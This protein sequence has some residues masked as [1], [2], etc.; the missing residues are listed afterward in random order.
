[1]GI[2][3]YNFN[4]MKKYLPTDSL[5]ELGDQWLFVSGVEH[6]TF[7]RDYFKDTGL[8]GR[9][10]SLDYMDREGVSII[11]DLNHDIN[12]QE[13]YDG[14]QYDV[15][16]DFG[17]LEHVFDYYQGLKN[18]YNLCKV[19]GVMI[20]S[21]PKVDSWPGHCFHTFE[22]K[23]FTEFCTMTG[24]ELIFIEEY[25]ACGNTTDGWEICVEA[26]KTNAEFP[27]REEFKS[28]LGPL[29][30]TVIDEHPQGRSQMGLTT[31]DMTKLSQK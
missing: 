11:L 4:R 25:P 28:K 9:Y 2:T 6:H 24:M 21:T 14:F 20:F 7:S 29:Y 17:T 31:E 16:T 10:E 13:N 23:F 22:S 15:I 18:A 30:L 8:I 12:E 1:M 5:C 3:D 27:T 26:R 19:G